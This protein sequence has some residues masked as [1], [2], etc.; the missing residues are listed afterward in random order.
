MPVGKLYGRSLIHLARGDWAWSSGTVV[1]AAFVKT[2]YTFNQDDHEFWSTVKA[3]ESWATGGSGDS[4]VG[5]GGGG[6]PQGGTV[7]ANKVVNYN[8][9]SN[10]SRLDADDLV[11]PGV[12]HPNLGGIVIYAVGASDAASPLIAF[13]DI[14]DVGQTAYSNVTLTIEWNALGLIQL[15]VAE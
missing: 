11:L 5:S 14:D 2:G 10:A 4:E 12:T 3:S 15:P 9:A 13:I 1:K 8:A 7:L 6:L